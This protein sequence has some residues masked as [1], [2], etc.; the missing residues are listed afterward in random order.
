MVVWKLKLYLFLLV[1]GTLKEIREKTHSHQIF[2][3]VY[4]HTS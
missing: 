1:H 4:A 3:S 2:I